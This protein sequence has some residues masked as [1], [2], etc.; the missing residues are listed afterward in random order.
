[1]STKLNFKIAVAQM[2]PQS[3]NIRKNLADALKFVAEAKAQGAKLIVFGELC[4]S[5]YLLGDRWEDESFIRNLVK[6]NDT[7]KAAS[8]DCAI[9]FGSIR[10]DFDRIGEDGRIRK[11]NAALVAQNGKWV[12]N[13]VLDGWIPKTNLPNYRMFDDS[14]HFYPSTKLFECDG[15]TIISGSQ[16]VSPPS[17]TDDLASHQNLRDELGKAMKAHGLLGVDHRTQTWHAREGMLVRR[18]RDAKA[19]ILY[20]NIVGL[21]NN[22]KNLVWFDGA[23]EFRGDDGQMRWAAPQNKEGVF[24]FN[25][26]ETKPVMSTWLT[27]IAENYAMTIEAMRDFYA[28]Y[29]RVII[30]LSGGI[31]SAVSAAM[32]VEALGPERILAINTTEFNPKTG[33]R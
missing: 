29:G 25:P 7:L 16:A 24:V 12:H 5:G 2:R 6:A 32:L 15:R 14:R 1:M 11:Y 28:S 21:Q 4:L 18:V 30:G 8:V 10:A 13:G 19:P 17:T 20:A 33:W 27:G 31:A 3:G 22:A 9:V 26:A 23:S